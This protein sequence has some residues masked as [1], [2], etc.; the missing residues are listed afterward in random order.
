[1]QI[2][3]EYKCNDCAAGFCTLSGQWAHLTA[4]NADQADCF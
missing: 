1:M 2:F 3:T 4:D